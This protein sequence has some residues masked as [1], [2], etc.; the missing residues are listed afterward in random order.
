MLICFMFDQVL[1]SS[2]NSHFVRNLDSEAF[3]PQCLSRPTCPSAAPAHLNLGVS[4]HLRVMLDYI[5]LARFP[6]AAFHSLWC[7][8]VLLDFLPCGSFAC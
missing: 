8:V 1:S 4:C 3:C 7:S 6:A 2:F 5:N